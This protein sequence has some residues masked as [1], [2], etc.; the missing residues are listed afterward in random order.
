MIR[1]SMTRARFQDLLDIHGSDV[2]A[3]PDADRSAAA[4]LI[5]YDADAAAAFA[6]ARRL[7]GLIRASLSAS[8]DEAGSEAIAARLIDA[9]PRALP[10]Q[11]PVDGAR[12]VK[13]ARRQVAEIMSRNRLFSRPILPRA[14]A[15]SLAA[16]CGIAL[17][18][19]WAHKI[20]QD[21]QIAAAS[22]ATDV[23]AVI[24]Q[25]ETAIG[26]F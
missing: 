16:A 1:P 19:F 11:A 20:T 25:S 7:D 5:A 23:M 15:L 3:W 8:P 4:R 12:L 10:P 13:P 18:V 24:F 22:E 14:A 2:A 26:T 6:E 21:E 17:G 9:L